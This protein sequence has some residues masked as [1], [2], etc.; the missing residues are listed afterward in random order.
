[1][2][3]LALRTLCILAVS[4]WLVGEGFLPPYL[5]ADDMA[6]I[7]ADL[8]LALGKGNYQDLARTFERTM[9]DAYRKVFQVAGNV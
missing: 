8:A 7:S 9:K 5:E 1:M 4:A 3:F 6:E 2:Q